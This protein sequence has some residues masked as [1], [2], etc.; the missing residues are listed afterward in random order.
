MSL[1]HSHSF[2]FTEGWTR[3]NVSGYFG[4]GKRGA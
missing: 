4:A 3:F 1:S 2:T